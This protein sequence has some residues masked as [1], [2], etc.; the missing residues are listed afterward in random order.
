MRFR[1]CEAVA[2]PNCA[3]VRSLVDF[4]IF[5][6]SFAVR[7]QQLLSCY[8]K[9]PNLTQ[10]VSDVCVCVFAFFSLRPG[11]AAAFHEHPG[12]GPEAESTVCSSRR[13]TET[14]IDCG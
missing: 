5:P 2:V 13:W 3:V 9:F 7:K 6:S 12:I 1:K 8:F 11:P 10:K 4:P 14:S